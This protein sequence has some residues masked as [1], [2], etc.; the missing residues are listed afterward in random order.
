MT[1]EARRAVAF[2]AGQL[3]NGKRRAIYDYDKG[4]YV[5]FSGSAD[6][7]VRLYNH[8]AG[9]HIIGPTKQFY[10]HGLTAHI[11]LDVSGKNFK[12]YDYGPGAFGV[13]T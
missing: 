4:G 2:I 8:Q 9:A 11:S 12:G 13:T 7:N 5:H 6:S 1:P 10:H 3:I